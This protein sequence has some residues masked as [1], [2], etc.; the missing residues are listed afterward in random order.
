MKNYVSFSQFMESYH[1]MRVYNYISHKCVF[2][3]HNSNFEL[4]LYLTIV[5]ISHDCDVISN[6]RDYIFI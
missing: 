1:D 4:I 3:F 6:N 2:I 5:T